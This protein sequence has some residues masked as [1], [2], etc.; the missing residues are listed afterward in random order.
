[1]KKKI[2]TVLDME[3]LTKA[4]ERAIRDGRPLSDLLQDALAAYLQGDA[5]RGDFERACKLFC[6]HGSGLKLEEID[7]LL[8]EDILAL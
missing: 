7:E 8:R 2:G 4:K 3:I 1:M 5:A 6:S